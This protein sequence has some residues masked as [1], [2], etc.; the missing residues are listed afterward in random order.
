MTWI[1]AYDIRSDKR[2]RRVEKVLRGYGFRVQYSVFACKIGTRQLE[3]L[4]REL[5][6]E[7]KDDDSLRFYMLCESCE[8][9]AIAVPDEDP[10]DSDPVVIF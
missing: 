6:A 3:R 1:V 9:K 2:R 5:V 4:R 10:F 8:R 7:V